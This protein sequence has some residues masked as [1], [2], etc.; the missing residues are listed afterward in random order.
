MVIDY[1]SAQTAMKPMNTI[2]PEEEEDYHDLMDIMIIYQ[3]VPEY[4]G[5]LRLTLMIDI[6]HHY[7]FFYTYRKHET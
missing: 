1:F 4:L 6:G 3:M 7:H 5:S 2:L